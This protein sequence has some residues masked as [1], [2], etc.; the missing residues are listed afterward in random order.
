MKTKYEK[1]MMMGV[2]ESVA[3]GQ[4]C[5]PGSIAAV[6]PNC[7]TGA[8]ADYTPPGA[9]LATGQTAAPA[10]CGTGNVVRSCNAGSTPS[11]TCHTG[12]GVE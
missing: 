9:C 12:I 5:A 1:P 2:Y 8:I 3:E 6:D 7:G 10:D 11:S 4:V